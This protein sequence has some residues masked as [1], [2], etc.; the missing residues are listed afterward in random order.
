LFV[1]VVIGPILI[2]DLTN[3]TMNIIYFM[4]HSSKP[5]HP[6]RDLTNITMIH[7]LILFM[8]HGSKP[9]QPN[10]VCANIFSKSGRITV[11]STPPTIYAQCLKR[12]SAT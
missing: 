1:L 3:I 10:L 5:C 7:H 4:H 11:A 2:V 9:C 8:Q 6:N 12:P